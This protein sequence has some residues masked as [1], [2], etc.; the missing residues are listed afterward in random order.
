F[1]TSFYLI[2]KDLR[3][4]K[5]ALLFASTLLLF[6][7]YSYEFNRHLTHTVLVTTIA[8]LTLLTY[9][10]LIKYK[11]WPYYAL[12]GIL[13]GL[14]LLSKYNYFLLI[15]VLFLASLH[16][17]E[18]RK[19]IFNPRILITISLCF[20][21]FFPHL[22]FVLKVG[23][24]CLKQLF[25]KRINAEN[26]NFFSLNLFLHTFL[27]CFLEIFLFL[28]IFW[29]FFRKNL[30]KSLKIVS[31]SLVFRY[32]WIYVFIVPLLTILLLRLGRFSS[33]WLAPIYPCLPLSLSTYYKEK[34]KKEKL[35]Y[36]FCIL[37]VTGVFLL[38]ALIGFMPD[39]LGKRERIHIPFVK[40]SKEL[41]KR[42]KEMGITDLR[43]IIIITNKKYLAANLKIYLKKTKIITI[44]KILEIKSN[45]NAKIFFVWRENEGINKLP[46]YFQYY[47][48]EI[49]IYPPIKA[50]YLHSKRKPLYVVGLAK[51][52]L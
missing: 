22:F 47:F 15:D 44:S 6:P 51:V 31:Y 29:L 30:S 25:L 33:K 32:L 52:K 34:D 41:K 7:T 42:F 19:L 23:K 8:A 20:F 39:L 12:L 46:P 45:K 16:S 35:F 27:S 38:R 50:Y 37:I 17:Q 13:F 49:I 21:L 18:T 28:I 10:K 9:L 5:I 3:G 26:K 36:V 4:A 1:Y 48:S 14:G 24:S 40:V 11:T 2:L 43:T